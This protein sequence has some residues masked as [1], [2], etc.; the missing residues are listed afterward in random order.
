MTKKKLI[1]IVSAIFIL[2]I[3]VTVGAFNITYSEGF[4]AGNIVK[5]TKKGFIF[6][7]TEGELNVGG[8]QADKSSSI[9]TFSVAG[10]EEA[11]VVQDL[12][13]A[14]LSNQRVKL[15]YQ[16]KLFTIVWRGDTKYFVTKVETLK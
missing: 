13:A 4:R 9:W 16:E 11:Q 15:Y 14:A 5:V 2:L 3:G 7:T 12:E 8:I 6:K 1:V 10:S